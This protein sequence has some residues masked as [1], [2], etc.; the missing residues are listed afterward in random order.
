MSEQP[1]NNWKLLEAVAH[2]VNTVECVGVHTAVVWALDPWLYH[3]RIH[4]RGQS[5]P[6]GTISSS[7]KCEK[8]NGDSHS[9]ICFPRDW[10]ERAIDRLESIVVRWPNFNGYKCK[11][12][13]PP[14]CVCVQLNVWK[15]MHGVN[16]A[17]L[18]DRNSSDAL[19][20]YRLKL[21][22]PL[23]RCQR[24]SR[25]TF[26]WHF[27]A[28]GSISHL[29]SCPSSCNSVTFSTITLFRLLVRACGAP[30]FM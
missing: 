4:Y 22:T 29:W 18:I 26:L 11:Q 17:H 27:T 9:C 16:Y 28:L 1:V 24:A 19:C 3:F 25:S 6:G 14:V 7:C 10:S 23:L 20:T 13:N 8:G 15:Q 2:Q 21:K 5:C 12:P 30:L